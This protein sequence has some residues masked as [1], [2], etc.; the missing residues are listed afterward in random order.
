MV[1]FETHTHTNTHA[2]A[3]GNVKVKIA[4]TIA[5]IDCQI[6]LSKVQCYDSTNDNFTEFFKAAMWC[7]ENG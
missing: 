3:R 1:Q 2:H 5:L 4:A 7:K 6:I